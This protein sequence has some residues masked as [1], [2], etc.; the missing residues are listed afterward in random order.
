MSGA[1]LH[2]THRVSAKLM[3]GEDAAYIV[4]ALREAFPDISVSDMGSYYAVE[5]DHE[6]VFD[7]A[8][9]SDVLGRPYRVA[10]LLAVLASF[11][12]AIDVTDEAIIITEAV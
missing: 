12:G 2:R 3:A 5:R 6:I 10:T 1:Q 8:A 7:I 11:N 9:I 4:D